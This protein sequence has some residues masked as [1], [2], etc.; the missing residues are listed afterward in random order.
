MKSPEDSVTRRKCLG[1]LTTYLQ[2]RAM[3]E[4]DLL[5]LK[6]LCATAAM[7]SKD[8]TVFQSYKTQWRVV[9]KQ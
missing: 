3:S 8:D 1:R 5:Q 4:L 6:A 2:Q 7:H 9:S